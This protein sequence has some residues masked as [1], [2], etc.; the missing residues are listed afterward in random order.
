MADD[1]ADALSRIGSVVRANGFSLRTRRRGER[2][3]DNPRLF[4][5]VKN[6]RRRSF[7]GVRLHGDIV[8]R[9]RS[10]PAFLARSEPGSTTWQRAG[11]EREGGVMSILHWPSRFKEGSDAAG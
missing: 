5:A 1:P 10:D 6:L 8:S 11:R 2:P 7:D 3:T 9:D 4:E